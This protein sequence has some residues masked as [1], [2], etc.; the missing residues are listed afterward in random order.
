MKKMLLIVVIAGLMGSGAAVAASDTITLKPEAC[1]KGPQIKLGEVADIS[2]QRQDA[3]GALE[4]CAAAA[5]GGSRRLE[6]IVVETKLKIAGF[7]SGEVQLD[8]ASSVIAN[9]LRMDVTQDVIEQNLRAFIEHE[10][11]WKAEEAVVE[12]TLPPGDLVVPDGELGFEWKLDPGFRFIGTGNVRGAITVD[13]HV[14]RS[15]PCRVSIEAYNTVAVAGA[16]IE[17]GTV[18]SLGNVTLERRALSGL[19]DATFTD[20]SEYV[21]M[22]ARRAI[23]AGDVITRRNLAPPLVIKRNQVVTVETNAGGLQLET[24]ARAMSDGAAGDVIVCVNANSNQPFQG[25]VRKDGVVVVE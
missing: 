4:L 1:V 8:G 2:G 17:R 19:K 22:V 21:G 3:L 23:A 25:V 13:G 24:Q 9:T 10:M 7:G 18:L 15:F 16:P 6:R 5:P 20:P 14:K 11:P 12:V